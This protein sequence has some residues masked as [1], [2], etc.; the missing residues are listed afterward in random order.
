MN[1][2]H[3][4]VDQ[5]FSPKK[6][7]VFKATFR[8]F[9]YRNFRLMWTGAF[10]STTGFFVQ[11]V[12]QSWLVYTMTDSAFLLGLTAFLAG[13]PILLLSLLGGVAADRMDRRKLLAASQYIQMLSALT[14]AI[15]LWIG[16]IEVW[17][18]M[19]AAFL[20][21]IGQ[22][23]GG[24]AYQALIPS[25]VEE[26]DLPNGVALM[27]IQFNLA[28]VIGRPIGGFIFTP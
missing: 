12:A 18:I 3:T 22:A 19:A 16:S 26:K 28:S 20:S 14:L 15:L 5:T 4:E 6:E 13:A 17:H 27:S 10:I 2:S 8:A 24:P 21:G 1:D 23:F 9:E 25:L 7:G 11:E